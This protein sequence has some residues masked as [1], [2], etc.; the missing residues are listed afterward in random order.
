MS[1]ANETMRSR[2]A[3]AGVLPWPPERETGGAEARALAR[4]A[5]IDPRTR[6]HMRGYRK[7]QTSTREK[8]NW[9]KRFMAPR[10][11]FLGRKSAVMATAFF[12]STTPVPRHR[13]F[14]GG[15][16]R[17]AGNAPMTWRFAQRR[18]FGPPKRSGATWA[19]I[20]LP[21]GGNPFEGPRSE[22]YPTPPMKLPYAS[23]LFEQAAR[24]LGYHP[25]PNPSATISTAYTNPD[26]ISRPGCAYCGFCDRFGCMIGAKAQP[27][28]TLLPIV[29]KQKNVSLRNNCAVRRIVFD[30]SAKR[31]R[32][33]QYV[34]ANGEEC[35]QPADL[36]VLGSWTL[37][38]TRLLLLSGIGQQYD[39]TTG[40]GAV[41]RNLTHQVNVPT[42]VFIDKPLNRFM[43]AAATGICVSDFDG[44]AFDH[45][46]LPFIRGGTFRVAGTGFQPIV[47]FGAVPPTVKERWGSEWKKAAIE[48]YDRI[49]GIGFAGEHIAY[50][51]HYFDLDPRYKDHFGDPLL[52]MTID[53]RQNELEMVKIGRA[54]CRERV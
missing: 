38:N 26:G 28:N 18:N 52:R 6:G 20:P 47:S 8:T 5:R 14:S 4:D 1:L 31:A 35:F 46:N 27:T 29:E 30:K 13:Y 21:E 12:G 49:T 43:G 42:Q 24:S 19:T 33:V 3:P 34:D 51:T 54:S 25:Y 44:D 37:N 45:S 39:P 53:W 48:W 2:C 7:A 40:K 32:G 9:R 16:P 50:K 11:I 22:E 36:V 15:L 23:A 17:R 10:V 41:G